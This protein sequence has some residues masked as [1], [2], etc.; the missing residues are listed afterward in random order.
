MSWVALRMLTGDRSKYFGLI[1]G[2]AFASLLMAH[3]VSIFAGI[4]RRTTSQIQDVREAEVWVMDPRVQYFDE[5]KPLQEGDLHR[6]RGVEGVAWAV[7][8]YKGWSAPAW[9]TVASARWCCWA[10]TTP[11]WWAPRAS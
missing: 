7:R 4:M 5:V 9:T 2:V 1:F 10:W 8:L 11:R 6:V 3:Q